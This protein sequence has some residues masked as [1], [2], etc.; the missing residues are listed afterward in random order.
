MNKKINI[1]ILTLGV[2][3]AHSLTA[4]TV[5]QA[6]SAVGKNL[7]KYIDFQASLDAVKN[8]SALKFKLPSD[9]TLRLPSG[10]TRPKSKTDSTPVIVK[11]ETSLSKF[12][13]YSKCGDLKDET[14]GWQQAC[15][16][17]G[18]RKPMKCSFLAVSDVNT[19]LDP[20]IKLIGQGGLVQSL[21]KD[22]NLSQPAVNEIAS[23]LTTVTKFF[24]QL[25]GV[26]K[27]LSDQNL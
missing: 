17:V 14:G 24:E 1:T 27:Q 16:T 12:P 7:Q 4:V 25:K 3:F 20:L 22:L 15:A 9:L 6:F 11:K 18:C 5:D 10:K 26:L 2:I 8:N 13:F 23:Q 19:L 21:L